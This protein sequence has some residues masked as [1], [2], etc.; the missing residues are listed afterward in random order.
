VSVRLARAL[1]GTPATV[2]Q[3]VIVV[4][5]LECVSPNKYKINHFAL[6]PLAQLQKNWIIAVAFHFAHFHFDCV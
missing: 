2:W 1:Y 3:P 4:N 5:G 6:Y